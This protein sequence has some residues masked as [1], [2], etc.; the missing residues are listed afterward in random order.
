MTD[1]ILPGGADPT[2]VRVVYSQEGTVTAVAD[3]CGI[4]HRT[5]RRALEALGL[6]APQPEPGESLA[7]HL[8]HDLD[9]D[10]LPLAGVESDD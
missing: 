7:A 2:R 6:R 3:A 5:A 4:G 10:D 1:D 8:E 9:S